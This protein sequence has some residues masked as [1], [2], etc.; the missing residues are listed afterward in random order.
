VGCEEKDGGLIDSA[1]RAVG[2]VLDLSSERMEDADIK[3]RDKEIDIDR[4]RSNHQIIHCLGI[5]Y[6]Q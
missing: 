5:C 3:S 2:L 4:Q 1:R 6:S